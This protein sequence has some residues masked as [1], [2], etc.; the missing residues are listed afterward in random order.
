MVPRGAV[1]EQGPM[2][3]YAVAY[4]VLSFDITD[5]RWF[6]VVALIVQIFLVG[7]AFRIMPETLRADKKR[8]FSWA[9]DNPYT[10]YR[11]CLLILRR[12]PVKVG[13]G[14]NQ[15]LS[16]GAWSGF[17][18]LITSYLMG[19]LQ[20]LQQTTML[21]GVVSQV[22]SFLFAT[23]SVR[24]NPRLGAWR[25]F[26]LGLVIQT[27]GLAVWGSPVF[28]VGDALGCRGT[29][30]LCT[31]GVPNDT[32]M[33]KLAQLMPFFGAFLTS[34]GDGLRTPAF[35]WVIS[36]R[37][38]QDEAAQ[39]YGAV[40]FMGTVGTAMAAPIYVAL[41]FHPVGVGWAVVQF[42]WCSAALCALSC[43]TIYIT[44]RLAPTLR[45]TKEFEAAQRSK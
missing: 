16:A 1:P 29:S 43:L 35:N 27:V 18:A 45:Y 11:S 23:L 38:S 12:D 33:F 26:L 25:A 32:R 41:L 6:W 34:A 28:F 24:L 20:Y 3:G 30:A 31:A 22:S 2:T 37:T 13:L 5:Y 14:V 42:L 21:P 10:Y 15:V 39:A 4:W 7:F 8:L 44:G 19:P 40:N 17:F 36:T 9:R